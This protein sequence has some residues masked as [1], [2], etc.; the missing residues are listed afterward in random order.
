MLKTN[1]VEHIKGFGSF[2]DDKTVKVGEN[3]YTADHILI[4]TGSK[5]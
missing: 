4:A 5:P 3:T 2:V 1:N